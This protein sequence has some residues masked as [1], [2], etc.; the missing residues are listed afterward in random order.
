M[1]AKPSF[2]VYTVIKREGKEDFWL[3]LGVAFPHEDGEGFNLLLQAL[4]IDGKLVLRTYKESEDE[5]D[6]P[7]RP[8]KR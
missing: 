1:A 7:K 2:R 4:P 5:D 8:N 6:R 3:N